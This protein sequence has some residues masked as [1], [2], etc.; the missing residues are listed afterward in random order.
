MKEQRRAFCFIEFE[1]DAAVKKVLEQT[2]HTL[3]GQEVCLYE[4]VLGN[5]FKSNISIKMAKM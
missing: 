4:N 3:G 5:A 2:S 1:A